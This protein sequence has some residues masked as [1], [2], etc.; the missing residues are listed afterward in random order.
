MADETKTL[1]I[2]IEY[3]PLMPDDIIAEQ[4]RT[5]AMWFLRKEKEDKAFNRFMEAR[6]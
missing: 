1:E 5:A 2:S 6:Q 3:N 4:A